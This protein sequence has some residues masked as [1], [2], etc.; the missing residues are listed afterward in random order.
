MIAN[1][2]AAIH[3]TTP[4]MIRSFA[5]R[6]PGEAHISMTRMNRAVGTLK[7][8]RDRY[9]LDLARDPPLIQAR[10]ATEWQWS[11]APQFICATKPTLR[12][13]RTSFPGCRLTTN[14]QT[15]KH[16]LPYPRCDRRHL[17]GRAIGRFVD[18]EANS[19][20]ACCGNGIRRWRAGSDPDRLCGRF[21]ISTIGRSYA[22][23][24]LWQSSRR[25]R[26]P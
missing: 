21:A 12:H 24:P 26:L 10:G 8:D 4:C 9:R 25:L 19:S 3:A 17:E 6:M 7:S 22:V 23:W 15:Q 18:V 1:A 5:T 11:E 16:S 13:Q 20:F 14:C 2:D